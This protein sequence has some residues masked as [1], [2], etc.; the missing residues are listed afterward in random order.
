L[1][2]T[3]GVTVRF[4]KKNLLRYSAV[5]I[6]VFLFIFITSVTS[7][8]ND[9]ENELIKSDLTEI[10]IKINQ[11]MIANYV[12]PTVAEES[13]QYLSKQLSRGNY[14]KFEDIRQL[15]SQLTHDLQKVTK[16]K[17]I[18]LTESGLGTRKMF[19]D[20]PV[21][22]KHLYESKV[23]AGNIGYFDLRAFEPLEKASDLI[24][25]AM[26]ELE[27]TSAIIFDMRN[28]GGGYPGTVRYLCSY[29][30]DKKVHL[31]SLHWRDGD[32]IE[33]FWTLDEIKG[34]KRPNVPVFVLTSDYTFS[35]AEEF[36]YN[37]QTQKRVTVIGE[38]TKGGAH[39]GKIFSLNS[40][41]NIFIPVGRAVNPITNSNWEGTGVE[42]DIKVKQEDAL[43][44]ALEL[45]KVA[46][47]EYKKNR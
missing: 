22:N 25:S 2:I 27:N 36:T 33:E 11:L 28:N 35:G 34:K 16:D 37:L 19:D 42:P 5:L 32:R 47:A 14:N 45:A 15:S 3:I 43:E 41:I 23:L 17:H 6:S 4:L 20:N 31:N 7:K 40:K 13:S 12:F 38:T 1:Q 18:R 44:K 10:V 29:L 8:S 24:S 26:K 21:G 30:F 9:N 39:P 46:A